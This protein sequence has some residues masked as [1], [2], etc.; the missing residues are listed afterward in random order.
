MT[1]S[2]LLP[3]RKYT[4]SAFTPS[5]AEVYQMT[6]TIHFSGLNTNPAFL[7]HLASNSLHR[8]DPQVSLL[9]C[10]IG[11][12]QVGLVSLSVTHPLGNTY[13]FHPCEG[14]PEVPDLARHEH[15]F[16]K[17]CMRSGKQN[18]QES[19]ADLTPFPRR[20]KV[21]LMVV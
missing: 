2:G 13:Q 5:T 3:S 21:L 17:I 12:R 6:T 16:V 7:I 18:L 19:K 11:F 4:L 10:W 20:L 15:F 1:C 14:N 8:V 9:P